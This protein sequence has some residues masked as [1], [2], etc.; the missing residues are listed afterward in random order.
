MTATRDILVLGGGIAGLATALRLARDGHRVTLLERDAM[1]DTAPADAFA[2]DRAGIAHF[3]QPHAFI[4]RGRKELRDGWPDVY[5]ALL[6]AG[7]RE[8]DVRRK[9]HGV[10][11]DADEELQYIAVRRPLIEWALRSAVRR[12]PGITVAA[13]VVATGLR[14][15]R[16]AVSGVDT[17][18]GAIDAAVVV[19]AMG[20]RS[21]VRGWI[22]ALGLPEPHYESSECG[23]IYY[24]R[25]H[26]LRPGRTLPDGPWLFSPRGDLG[27]MGYSSFPGDNDSFAVLFA[28]PTGVEELKVFRHAPAYEA[29]MARMPMLGEWTSPGMSMPETPVMPMGGLRNSIV[30]P[31]G[32][33]PAGL[34]LTGDALGHGDP[35]LAHGLSFALIHAAAL[36]RALAAHADPRDTAAAY[37]ADVMPLVRERYAFATAVD[38]QRL[39]LWSGGTVDVTRRDGDY[40]LFTLVA[41]GAVALADDDV[42]RTWVRRFGLLES[43]RVL[44]D[45]EPLQRHIEQRFAELRASRAP[46]KLPARDELLAEANAAVAR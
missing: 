15:D 32:T 14:V 16:G 45:D 18:A 5:D 28:V 3:R 4:P 27:Y 1:P 29:A 33:L 24:S 17:G 44:D 40:E 20:R 25:Y 36:A 34:Y 43:T 13:P 35:V 26:R 22:T 10:V 39:T 23:V 41:G 31:A 2:C 30:E 8:Y 38:R 7:A 46:A 9:L 21:P 37:E 12:Q 19:D 11:R 42:L 6:A